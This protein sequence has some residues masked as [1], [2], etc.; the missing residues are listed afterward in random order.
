V[1]VGL[2]LSCSGQKVYVLT[3]DQDLLQYISWARTQ[4]SLKNETTTPKLLEGLS[5]ITFMDLVHRGCY[6]SSDQIMKMLRFV[7]DDTVDRMNRKD[8]MALSEDKG[9]KIVSDATQIMSSTFL[10]SMKI[11]LE[12][13]G[14][15]A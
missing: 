7:I 15:A 9:R 14:V 13:Q 4:P 8:P 2:S 10:E 1:Y 11:K 6:I 5:G 3:N 12:K